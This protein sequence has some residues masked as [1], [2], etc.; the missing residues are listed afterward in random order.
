MEQY[1]VIVVGAGVTGAAVAR[2]LSRRKGRFLV[3]ERAL[4]VCEGTSKANSAIVHAGFDAEP[5]TWKARMNVRGNQMMDQLSEEL[6]IPFKRIGAFVVCFS[7]EDL[8][9]LRELY[10]RGVK[11][12]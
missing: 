3:A 1:D 6:D 11:T 10:G 2:E 5:G 7:Q 12:A 8:P 4:D 9:K